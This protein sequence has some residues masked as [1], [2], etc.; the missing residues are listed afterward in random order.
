MDCMFSA[1]QL[2]EKHREF[3][4][5]THIVF[6]DFK[7]AFDSVDRDKLWIIVSKKKKRIPSHLI[8]IIQKIYIYI[9]IYGKHYKS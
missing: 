3:N 4:I 2:S 7:K 9:Y 6:I 1:S 5:P 8:T